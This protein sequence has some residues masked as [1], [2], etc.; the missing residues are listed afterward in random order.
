MAERSEIRAGLFVVTG[1]A[2]LGVGT[3]WIVGFSPLAG[4]QTTYEVLMKMSSGV[5][6]GDRVRV[7]GIE[8]GRVKRV[9]LRAG[10]EWPVLFHVTLDEGVSLTTGSTARITSDGLLGAPYLEIVAGPSDGA[11]LPPGSRIM[12]T[13]GGTVTH[14]LEGLG[15]ATDRLPALLDQTNELVGK[16]N[17]EIEPLLSRFQALLSEQ[18]IAAISDSLATLSPTLEEV[19][20]RLSELVSRLD[21]LAAQLEDGIRGVP[22]LTSEVTALVDDLRQAIGPGGER[23][24]GVFDSA[25][26]TLG[27][28]E[29][30]LSA[31]GGNS[32]ELEAM[33]RDLR[34]AAAN[35]KSLSQTLK[36]RPA[37]LMRF[38]RPPDRKPGEGVEP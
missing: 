35:L 38:P 29:D 2:I 13:E 27:S 21:S 22:E 16:I 34:A 33:L 15:Q 5:R 19:G 7:S 1:L 9:D 28:A 14:T 32:A 36:E 3:L 6:T 11:P 17:R 31:V 8:V 20:P 37:L 24:A 10:E 30:A 4:R 25:E 12:G 26:S 23:L 18:N